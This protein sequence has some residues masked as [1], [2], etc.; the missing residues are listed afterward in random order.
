VLRNYGQRRRGEYAEIGLNSRLDELH[1]AILRTALLPRLDGWLR[2]RKTIAA[3]YTNA[4]ADS[5][6]RPITATGQSAHHLFPVEVKDGDRDTIAHLFA[7][8]GISV[9]HHYPFVCSNQEAA[10]QGGAAQ[11]SQPL[12]QRI[13]ERELSLPIHPYLTD[14]E[15]DEVIQAC[16]DVCG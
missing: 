13:A 2:R 15:V 16:L 14:H 9:G 3:G 1:A 11:G 8:R 4:L 10:R 5:A 12:A 6:L 7:E